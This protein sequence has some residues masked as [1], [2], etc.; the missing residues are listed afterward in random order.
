MSGMADTIYENRLVPIQDLQAVADRMWSVREQVLLHVIAPGAAAKNQHEESIRRLDEEIFALLDRYAQNQ[1]SEEEQRSLQVVR[2]QWSAF[3]Q[4]R[5][6]VLDA[7]R[8]GDQ[9]WAEQLAYSGQGSQA[10]RAAHE[11]MQQLID[12]NRQAAEE[13][14]GEIQLTGRRVNVTMIL[15]LLAAVAVSVVLSLAIIR[16]ITGPLMVLAEA[17]RGVAAGNLARS[18]WE[19]QA[20]WKDEIGQLYDAFRDTV[21]S[22]RQV[23]GEVID[24]SRRVVVSS[25]EMAGMAEQAAGGTA[26]IAS[27]VEQVA[28]GANDQARSAEDTVRAVEQLQQA[29]D[30]IAA[31]ARQ[32]A[33]HVQ[34]TSEALSDAARAVDEAM[35]ATEEVSVAAEQALLAARAGDGAVPETGAAMERIR[36]AARD[37]AERVKELGSRSE[38]IGEIVKLISDI[39]DQTNL[40]ALNAAIEAARAGEHGR[41]FAVVADE[42]RKLAERSQQ[43]TREI[44]ALVG[45]IL[46]G[47]AAAVSSIDSSTEAVEAGSSLA[48]DTGRALGE[49]LAAMEQTNAKVQAIRQATERV[50]AASAQ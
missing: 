48:G 14:N 24:A 19:D 12:V 29:I 26:Q 5:D 46:S 20:S 22:L 30:Q 25:R 6:N 10:F 27:A 21:R 38:E 44:T 3:Q 11:A 49:I 9:V 2:D 33:R 4:A 45:T 17:A 31:G 35:R 23:V 40:L 1:L 18:A 39:A 43:A 36:Q 34:E 28:Q 50:T 7:S 32:Q 42:V 47:V 37:V 13:L 8:R 16:M 15:I 41:G